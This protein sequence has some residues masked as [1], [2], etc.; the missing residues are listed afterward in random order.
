M[1]EVLPCVAWSKAFIMLLSVI[2]SRL[3][4]ASSKIRMGVSF[5]IAL[6]LKSYIHKAFP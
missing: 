4:V 1:M 6:K 2:E 5:K 3:E